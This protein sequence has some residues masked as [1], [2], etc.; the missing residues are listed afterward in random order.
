MSAEK[1]NGGRV[2]RTEINEIRECSSS[3]C[4]TEAAIDLSKGKASS[5]TQKV[6]TSSLVILALY[7]FH[8]TIEYNSLYL[9][10]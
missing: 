8:D 2:E 1:S 3:T 5:N 7:L 4:A 9:L 6:G 10:Q